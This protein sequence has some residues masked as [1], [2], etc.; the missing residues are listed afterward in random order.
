M[1][2]DDHEKLDMWIGRGIVV[3]VAIIVILSLIY[4]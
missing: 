3:I 2:D 1:S 4:G